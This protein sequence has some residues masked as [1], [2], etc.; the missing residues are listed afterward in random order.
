MTEWPEE[1]LLTGLR[2]REGR[3]TLEIRWKDV[4]IEILQ[5]WQMRNALNREEWKMLL[6]FIQ[7]CW[8]DDDDK[9]K[10]KKL[11]NSFST[12]LKKT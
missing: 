6:G 7:D 2:E 9:G 3:G 4:W 1:Y 10:F 12:N 8:S 11:W 5:A